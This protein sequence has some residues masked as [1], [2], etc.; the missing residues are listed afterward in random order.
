MV[1]RVM[2]EDFHLSVFIPAGLA[3]KELDTIRTALGGP[4]FRQRLL[5]AVRRAFRR[6]SDLAKARIRLS[7]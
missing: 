3:A 2:L 4:A 6:E 1:K 5:R 7:R